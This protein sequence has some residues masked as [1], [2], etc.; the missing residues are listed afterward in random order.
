[1]ADKITPDEVRAA[2]RGFWQAF[3]SKSADALAELYAHEGTVFGSESPRAEPG[4][5]ATARRQREYFHVHSSV[6]AEPGEIEVIMLG[7]TA[8][9]ATYNFK[10]H[11]NKQ[12]TIMGKA[13]EESIEG[14]RATQVFALDPKGELK[15]FHE[16]LSVVAK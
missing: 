8:A 9:V 14:G 11:A 15:I 6:K 12:T 16:H 10:F 3:E 7:D 4:R 13:S 5:L 1:V 2:V